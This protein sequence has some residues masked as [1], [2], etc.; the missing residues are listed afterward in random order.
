M[1]R[2][3]AER[4][5]GI[6]RCL[7][8]ASWEF[9][10]VSIKSK[11]RRLVDSY[12][13]ALNNGF[14]SATVLM[15]EEENEATDSIS[16]LTLIGNK[17]VTIGA[18]KDRKPLTTNNG[19]AYLSVALICSGK[20]LVLT[21]SFLTTPELCKILVHKPFIHMIVSNSSLNNN[22]CYFLIYQ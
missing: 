17:L 7:Q 1:S 5:Q 3:R 8:C 15:V 22:T 19:N 21:F 9:S 11:I 12:I 16:S 13:A 18:S 20:S 14:V 2:K 10:K 6:L 4:I